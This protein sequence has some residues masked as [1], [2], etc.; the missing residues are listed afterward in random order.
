MDGGLG[1][2]TLVGGAGDD[3]FVAEAGDDIVELAGEGVD[4]V[5]TWLGLNRA[6]SA[7]VDNLRL[8][9]DADVDGAGNSRNNLL[10]GNQGANRLLGVAGNDTLR[11]FA[12]DDVLTGGVG[13]DRY[14]IDPGGGAD[15]IVESAGDQGGV[16]MVQFLHSNREN[17]VVNQAGKHLMILA[18][19]T[20]GPP[21]EVLI[22]DWFAAGQRPVEWVQWA[23]GS[24]SSAAEIDGM[25]IAAGGPGTLELAWANQWVNSAIHQAPS[26]I[27]SLSDD[28]DEP[29]IPRL[30]VWMDDRNQRRWLYGV[31]NA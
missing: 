26:W 28:E 20:E 13:D 10:E 6:L 29:Q 31:A 3:V 18:T 23:D 4:R 2:D 17:V 1:V 22:K 15:L 21:V 12:G 7:N 24:S 5:E 16:D 25:V 8:L 30:P 9:G 11:G 27:Q 19:S 14:L